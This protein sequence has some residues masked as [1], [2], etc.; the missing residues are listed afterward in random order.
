MDGKLL[1]VSN[2]RDMTPTEVVQRNKS[3][4]DIVRGLKVLKLEI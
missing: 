1:L 4:A 3:L 2:V